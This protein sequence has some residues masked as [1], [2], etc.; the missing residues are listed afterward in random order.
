M[1]WPS[2]M[3]DTDT[4]LDNTHSCLDSDTNTASPESLPCAGRWP[5]PKSSHEK[6]MGASGTGGPGSLT[7]L[8]PLPPA[9]LL[10]SPWNR[11]RPKGHIQDFVVFPF[12]SFPK[13]VSRSPGW[14]HTCYVPKLLNCSLHLL[15]ADH[16][17][18]PSY[19]AF[20]SLGWVGVFKTV[21][22]CSPS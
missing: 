16:R 9:A 3:L 17:L 22:L 12:R 13:A 18:V 2:T 8:W 1:T 5:F 10:S 4:A 6:G 19:P 15:R 11:A 14:P 20:I 21:S 7:C